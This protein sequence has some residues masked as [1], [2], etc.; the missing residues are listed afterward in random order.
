MLAL[1]NASIIQ[2]TSSIVSVHVTSITETQVF[3]NH[4]KF[5]IKII[6]NYDEFKILYN[7]CLHFF[8]RQMRGRRSSESERQGE[9]DAK[10]AHYLLKSSAPAVEPEVPTHSVP[11][12]S[13]ES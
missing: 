7:T 5:M 1:L 11:R 10:A 12:S 6:A 13:R 2:H 9:K 8:F 3:N 4:V